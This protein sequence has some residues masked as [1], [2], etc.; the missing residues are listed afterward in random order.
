MRDLIIQGLGS[1][2][3]AAQ[4]GAH[5]FKQL[6]VF[7][8]VRVV[9]PHDVNPLLFKNIKQGGFLTV[10]KNGGDANLVKA[11][12]LAY[13]SELTCMNVVNQV[14]SPVT[15][16]IDEVL[17]EQK[18][19]QDKDKQRVLFNADSDEDENDDKFQDKNIGM[20]TKCGYC[21]TDLKSYIP[22]VVC[23]TMVALWFSHC[24]MSTNTSMKY[25][26]EEKKAIIEDRKTMVHDIGCLSLSMKY[27]L[28]SSYIAK[29]KEIAKYLKT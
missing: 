14:N 28:Q 9:S 6:K 29:Y 10:S 17:R 3:H 19:N 15:K 27:A 12:K 26:L 5:L 4:Y 1:S 2:Y 8:T 11:V 18:E 23:L 7:D 22:Q 13:M 24:K 25:S 20:Y 21:Y 16:A